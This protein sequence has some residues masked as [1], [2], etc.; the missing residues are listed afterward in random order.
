MHQPM[1]K[2]ALILVFLFSLSFSSF[3]QNR[4]GKYNTKKGGCFCDYDQKGGWYLAPFAGLGSN[5]YS[6][7]YTGDK[8]MAYEFG[9][10]AGFNPSNKLSLQTGISYSFLNNLEHT[11]YAGDD[12]LIYNTW[13]RDMLNVPIHVVYR[14]TETRL[15]PYISGGVNVNLTLRD[16]PLEYSEQDLNEKGTAAIYFEFNPGVLYSLSM[17]KTI[18]LEPY[19]QYGIGNSA[20]TTPKSIVGVRVGLTFHM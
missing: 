10:R 4:S 19:F 18:F 1:F 17:K 13:H 15:L 16:K 5:T 3:G 11:L 8:I 2:R 7:Y 12:Q 14:L 20:V 6:T 9:I